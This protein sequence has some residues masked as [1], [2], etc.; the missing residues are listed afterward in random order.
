M[1]NREDYSGRKKKCDRTTSA[2]SA[3]SDDSDGENTE[4]RP[5]RSRQNGNKLVHIQK[6]Y[7]R[8]MGK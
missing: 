1:N 2:K 3:K 8:Q 7:V 4:Y 5:S 6:Y